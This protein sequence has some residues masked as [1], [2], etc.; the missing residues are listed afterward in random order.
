MSATGRGAKREE[1]DFYET[2]R[3]CVDLIMP[4]LL[5]LCPNACTILDPA[6]GRGAILNAVKRLWLPNAI[7]KGFE[8]HPQRAAQAAERGHSVIQRDALFPLTSDWRQQWQAD[9]IIMNPPYTLADQFIS[10]ALTSNSPLVAALLRL[11]YIAPKKRRKVWSACPELH[12][13]EERPAFE[14]DPD[15]PTKATDFAE[16][17]WFLWHEKSQPRY[18]ILGK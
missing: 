14:K 10:L 15:N 1:Y 6:A 8:L 5:E 17:A 16:Y 3:W 4:R 9:M 12:I 7:T 18:Y 2:P 11:D 13:L